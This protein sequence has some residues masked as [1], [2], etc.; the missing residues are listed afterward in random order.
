MYIPEK[1]DMINYEFNNIIGIP[2]LSVK[3][4]H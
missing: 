3:N 2:Y 1:L 4:V